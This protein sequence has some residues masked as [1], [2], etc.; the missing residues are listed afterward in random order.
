MSREFFIDYEIFDIMGERCKTLGFLVEGEWSVEG[1]PS[2]WCL[3]RSGRR[4]SLYFDDP[5][6]LAIWIDT[7]TEGVYLGLSGQY[8]KGE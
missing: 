1:Y 4:Q 6:E 8:T 2:G 7:F 3:V 5:E